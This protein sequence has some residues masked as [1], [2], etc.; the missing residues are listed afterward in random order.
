MRVNSD[1][2]VIIAAQNLNLPKI[3]PIFTIS[4]VKGTN[5]D[6]LKKFLHVLPPAISKLDREN[7]IQQMPEFRVNKKTKN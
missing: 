7:A 6:K 3:C 5:L 2:D 4:C 1:D